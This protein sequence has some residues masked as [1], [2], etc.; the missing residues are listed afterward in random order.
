MAATRTAAPTAILV[1]IIEAEDDDFCP[2]CEESQAEGYSA[3]GE[4]GAPDEQWEYTTPDEVW[5][6]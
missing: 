3:C 6:V 5:E 1:V 2:D 4:C